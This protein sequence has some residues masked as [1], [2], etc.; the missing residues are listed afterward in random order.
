MRVNGVRW[1]LTLMVL[2]VTPFAGV[3]G[4]RRAEDGAGIGS[5]GAEPVN[6]FERREV[7]VP[8]VGPAHCPFATHDP[9]PGNCRLCASY[10]LYPGHPGR[11]VA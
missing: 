9:C 11:M 4:S 6:P 7:L 3:V 8:R 2:A 1:L 10:R 5:S